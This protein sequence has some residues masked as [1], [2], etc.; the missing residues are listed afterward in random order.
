MLLKIIRF[1]NLNQPRIV[2]IEEIKQAGARWAV[3]VEYHLS[4]KPG[5]HSERLFVYLA[6][7]WLRYSNLVGV[8][9]NPPEPIDIVVREF[10]SFQTN[11]D[12][13]HVA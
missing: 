6:L 12:P 5:P 10:V 11:L 9:D 1:I 7:K 8:P 3:D 4:R 2:E 13:F